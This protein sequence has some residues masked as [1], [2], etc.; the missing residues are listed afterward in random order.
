VI[1][2]RRNG[3]SKLVDTC[4]I[5]GAVVL[6]SAFEGVVEI[7]GNHIPDVSFDALVSGN[8]VDLAGELPELFNFA[9]RASNS[10]LE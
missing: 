10:L 3:L 1:V 8:P 9:L 5:V 2:F 7:T 4:L 6:I